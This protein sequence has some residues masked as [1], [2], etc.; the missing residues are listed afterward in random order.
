MAELSHAV[1]ATRSSTGARTSFFFS[2]FF[3]FLSLFFFYNSGLGEAEPVLRVQALSHY[4]PRKSRASLG[5]LRSS[6]RRRDKTAK[7]G[8]AIA[9]I[10]ERRM[11]AAFARHV[12]VGTR[13]GTRTSRTPRVI[14]VDA[15]PE[16]PA[17]CLAISAARSV[18]R[19]LSPRAGHAI[20]SP[21]EIGRRLVEDGAAECIAFAGV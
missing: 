8:F 20:A 4:S 17:G 13:S 11:P 18:G 16:T 21:P 19:G 1:S 2:C 3:F 14:I 15:E 7:S 12:K 10:L 9:E 5:S 6:R